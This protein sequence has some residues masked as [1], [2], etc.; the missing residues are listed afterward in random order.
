MKSS[1]VQFIA[2][3]GGAIAAVAVLAGIYYGSGRLTRFDTPLA[4]Y[5]AAT[6]FAAFAM[7][8]RYLMW[9]Q[10]PATWR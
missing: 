9:V 3:A 10:R 5:A 1:R 6:V 7:I 4:A 2:M 8:Y